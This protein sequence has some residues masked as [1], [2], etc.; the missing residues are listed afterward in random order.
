MSI[1]SLDI[2]GTLIGHHKNNGAFLDELN[3]LSKFCVK[4]KIEIIFATGRSL[5]EV[6]KDLVLIEI[7]KPIFIISNCGM[8]IYKRTKNNYIKL[9]SYEEILNSTCDKELLTCEKLITGLFPKM[10]IQETHRQFKY[11][12]SYYIADHDLKILQNKKQ[13]INELFVNSEI[14]VTFCNNEPHYLDL[15]HKNATKFGA[16]N[17]IIKSEL[18][19]SLDEVCYFGDNGNDIPCFLN[20]NKS[21]LFNLFEEPL[22]QFYKIDMNNKFLKSAPGAGSILFTMSQLI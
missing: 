9:R 10:K 15:Q 17:F 2:D 3:K 6:Y 21:Y 22:R 5:E 8:D 1:L 14:I 20:L 13:E 7:L 12:K 19:T 11:K 18:K 16:L 4:K